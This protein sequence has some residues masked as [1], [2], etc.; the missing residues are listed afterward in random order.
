MTNLNTVLN[1]RISRLSR[2]EIKSHTGPTRRLA[3]QHRR[4]IAVL[5]RMVA[6]L[7]KRLVGL[8][9]VATKVVGSEPVPELGDKT[10]FRVDGLVAHRKRLGLSAD[11]YGKLVGVTGL[12]VYAWESRKSRPRDAQ[13]RQA[14]C[15][16]RHRQPQAEKRPSFSAPNPARAAPAAVPPPARPPRNSFVIFSSPN[17]PPP[18]P[19]STSPGN[20]AAG[21]ATPTTR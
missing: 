5:K 11:N 7:Q 15:H 8:E 2:K 14:L 6:T 21:P 20:P 18:V 3:L 16:S 1:E 10:R 4:D 13:P 17:P 12:T 9:K 19:R